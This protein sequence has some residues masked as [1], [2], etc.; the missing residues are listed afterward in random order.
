[1]IMGESVPAGALCV[2]RPDGR[3][4]RF[5]HEPREEIAGVA[6]IAAAAG[7]PEPPLLSDSDA[8]MDALQ[9]DFALRN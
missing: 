9:I 6:T 5:R 7:A 1:M 2:T 3:L 8:I 4:Y